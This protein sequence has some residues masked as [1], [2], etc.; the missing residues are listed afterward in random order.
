MI[1]SFDGMVNYLDHCLFNRRSELLPQLQ[2]IMAQ[3]HKK[4]A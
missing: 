2:G 3:L 4:G 1:Y